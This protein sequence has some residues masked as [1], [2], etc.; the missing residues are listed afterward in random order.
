MSPWETLG[1]DRQGAPLKAL[2]VR[3][4]YA[5]A[6]IHGGKDVENRSWHSPFRGRVLVHAGR[7]WHAVGPQ[8]L[9]RRMG[10]E[11]PADLPLG[12]IVGM[13]EIVDCVDAHESRWFEG[14]WG[15]VLRNPRPLP[16]VPCA[17]HLGFYDVPAEVL[18]VLGLPAGA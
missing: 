1:H 12:G 3:Q 7:H 6:I 2:S 11:V 16:F 10:V 5:W 9:S 14:P 17:G 8:E 4:P 18:A 15:F 13:V